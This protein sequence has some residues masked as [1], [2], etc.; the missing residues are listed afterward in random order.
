RL[1]RRAGIK[2]ISTLVYQETRAVLKVF[3]QN[4]VHGTAMYTQ[5]ANRKTETGRDVICV[6]KHYGRTLYGIDL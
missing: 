6:L 3:V 4:L 5:H 2:L 1:A